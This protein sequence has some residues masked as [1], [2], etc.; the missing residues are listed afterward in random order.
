MWLFAALSHTSFVLSH[1]VH[2]LFQ[3][4][5]PM[6]VVQP[7]GFHHLFVIHTKSICDKY[8][9]TWPSKPSG[10]EP[11]R[12][13]SGGTNYL[14]YLHLLSCHHIFAPN[15]SWMYTRMNTATYRTNITGNIK[16]LSNYILITSQPFLINGDYLL[17]EINFEK[18]NSPT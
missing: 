13:T 2:T 14:F 4:R 6:F 16:P 10:T 5:C 15:L 7:S 9:F 8:I 3:A 18:M 17:W 11:G 12:T 1:K